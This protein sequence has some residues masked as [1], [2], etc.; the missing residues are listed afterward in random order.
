MEISLAPVLF[1]CTLQ[2][3]LAF[4]DM[5][6]AYRK[7]VIR[8]GNTLSGLLS[9]WATLLVIIQMFGIPVPGAEEN[10]TQWGGIREMQGDTQVMYTAQSHHRLQSAPLLHWSQP[11]QCQWFD[12][13]IW[14]PSDIILRK[15]KTSS[16]KN[17]TQEKVVLSPILLTIN[18]SIGRHNSVSQC[19]FLK[20]N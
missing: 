1:V 6:L 20:F 19:N 5:F 10:E 11:F 15:G 16:F 13:I 18:H 3:Y 12:E 7:K 4:A 9:S 8:F 14:L 2:V 17:Y